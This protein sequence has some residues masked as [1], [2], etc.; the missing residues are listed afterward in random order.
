MS[1]IYQMAG[2]LIRRLNQISLSV[3]SDETKKRGFDLTSIQFA[4]LDAIDRNPDADQATIAGLIAYDRPTTGGVID[5]LEARGLILRQINPND[6][7][8]R[9]VTLTD[10]GK[11][12]LNTLRP[13]V[14]ALQTEIL[15]GLDDQEKA[16]FIALASKIAEAGNEKSRAPLI[17]KE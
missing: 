1:E 11:T 5:R 9:L 14:R 10:D 6:R 2:H 8:A 7:R 13:I 15:D 3:F 17:L 16:T 12:T 4:I